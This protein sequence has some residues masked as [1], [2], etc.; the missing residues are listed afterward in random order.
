MT[1]KTI[2]AVRNIYPQLLFVLGVL[3][4]LFLCANTYQSAIAHDAAECPV[5]VLTA[6]EITALQEELAV[7]K[8]KKDVSLSPVS[9]SQREAIQQALDAVN[10]VE[11]KPSE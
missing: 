7:C 11:E 2:R 9:D 5:C 3:S 4:G 1:T 6:E 10:A 8:E